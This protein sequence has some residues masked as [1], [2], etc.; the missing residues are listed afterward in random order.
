LGNTSATGQPFY[1]NVPGDPAIYQT[2]SG[3][4]TVTVSDVK[5]T[6]GNGTPMTGWSLV[7]GDAET[8]DAGESITWTSD[9]PFSLLPNSPGDP[10]GLNVSSPSESGACSAPTSPDGLTPQSLLTG[11]TSLTVEGASSVSTSNPRTGTVMLE[12]PAPTTLT[13]TLVGTGLEG[14]FIGLL[15]PS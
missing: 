4:T 8:T 15:L 1:T 2:A 9:Q 10:V 12:A 6:N 7:T 3:T 5:V 14:V 13:D 11:G